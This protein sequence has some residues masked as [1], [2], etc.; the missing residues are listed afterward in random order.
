MKN[1]KFVH[2]KQEFCVQKNKIENIYNKKIEIG[3]NFI[4]KYSKD[5]TF[6]SNKALFNKFLSI[7][8][9]KKENLN[10]TFDFLEFL[11]E[12]EAT[13]SDSIK[14][15][16]KSQKEKKLINENYEF[17]KNSEKKNLKF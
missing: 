11:I 7:V 4:L 12:K 8:S 13:T 5:K 6:N 3:N 14:V 16:S 15:F 1:S 9:G 17:L 2:S 10:K